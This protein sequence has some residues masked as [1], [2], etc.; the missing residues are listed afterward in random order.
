M[1]IAC[2]CPL[3]FAACTSI[4]PVVRPEV[5]LAGQWLETASIDADEAKPVSSAWWQDFS[6]PQLDRLIDTAF[7]GNPDLRIQGERIVQAELAL[8]NA[9]ASLFPSLN[10]SGNSGWNRS[11]SGD[12]GGSV[13]SERKN[14]S[15]NLSAS[16]E[17]DL[18]GRIAASVASSEASLQAS[19][20][21]FDAAR[22]SLAA[23]IATTY[24]QHLTH[25]RRLAIAKENLA[26]AE[27][28][29]KVVEARYHN[30]AVSALDLSRQQTAV[31]SQR[32]AIEPLAVDVRQ[33][34]SALAILT[35]TPP[36][37]FTL[38]PEVAEITEAADTLDALTIPSIAPGL[39]AELLLRRPDL[40]SN[41]AQLTAA[42][43]NITV[44]RAELFPKLSLSAAAGMASDFLFSLAD[45]S[46]SASISAS[47]VQSIFDGGRLRAQVDIS[48]SR[49][50]ELVES[51]RK[52]ILTAL[53]EVED[54][55]GNVA[56]DTHHEEAQRQILFEAERS[57]RLAESRYHAGADD[58]LTVLDAQRNRF[59]AQEQLAQLR[60]ARLVDAVGLYK[61][62]GGGWRPEGEQT[63]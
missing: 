25:Q 56:R 18:W 33:S 5:H 37:T 20:H 54:A 21:D 43:A 28:V 51:Y 6:S 1:L 47:V 61:V 32:A 13:V 63:P 12:R 31:L 22:L 58:L 27:R 16:Y 14:S 46:N 40:A 52:N 38:D 10:L 44:A 41:E 2:L 8:G 35:G 26:I 50:R 60:L 34:R 23:S 57:L 11:D 53:K 62:L 30:G 39:P 59:S 49:Q 3:V 24:F 9:R 15:L 19:H 4:E 29:L 55:L 17:L 42:A 48:R 45:P 36:Q 7:Q